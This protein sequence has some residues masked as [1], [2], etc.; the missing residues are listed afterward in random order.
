MSTFDRLT[1]RP[2]AFLERLLA[3][4]TVSRQTQ[5][6]A[7]WNQVSEHLRILPGVEQVALAGWP[8]LAGNGTNGFVAVNGS[9][10]L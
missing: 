8:L 9:P 3:L 10:A 5:P 1:H 6:L 7:F 2:T 4:D